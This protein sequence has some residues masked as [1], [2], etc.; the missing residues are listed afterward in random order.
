MPKFHIVIHDAQLAH[1]REIARNV[2][3]NVRVHGESHRRKIER[4]MAARYVNG[5]RESGTIHDT[6]ETECPDGLPNCRNC[7]DP[8]HAASC[9]A[10]EHCP[11]CGTKHGL[12]PDA[13]LAANGYRLE[14]A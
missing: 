12:A 8:Y 7:G 4:M 11:D 6:A 14:S 5:P 3:A 1:D 9:E 13:H 10:S 2:E